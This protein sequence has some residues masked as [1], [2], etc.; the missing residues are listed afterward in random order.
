MPEQIQ[1]PETYIGWSRWRPTRKERI[2]TKWRYHFKTI[3]VQSWGIVSI[4]RGYEAVQ[5]GAGAGEYVL[6]E[7]GLKPI[8]E[9]VSYNQV[10]VVDHPLRLRC[11]TI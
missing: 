8:G 1:V 2:V 6:W 4:K 3:E 10:L 7:W 9:T 5:S 11:G